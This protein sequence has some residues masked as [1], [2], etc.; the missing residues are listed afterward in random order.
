MG[1]ASTVTVSVGTL[2]VVA[3]ALGG[4][5]LQAGVRAASA[6]LLVAVTFRTL[7]RD[8]SIARE[9]WVFLAAGGVLALV[10][11]VTRVLHG[12]LINETN[13]FPSVAEAPGYLGYVFIILSARSFWRHRARRSD[14]E[15]ALDGLLVDARP[16]YIEPDV[17]R[18]IDSEETS[19]TGSGSGSG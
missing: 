11:A 15:A 14:V 4:D 1:R 16:M 19:Q 9:P 12:V 6:L 13:P 7:R 3:A 2:L 17:Y 10:S 5:A 8:R 18:G